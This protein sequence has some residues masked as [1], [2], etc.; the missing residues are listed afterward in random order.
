MNI[1][2]YKEL[3]RRLPY[4][5]QSFI[6]HKERWTKILNKSRLFSNTDRFDF[7]KGYSREDLL[8]M[9]ISKEKV[10]KILMWGYPIGGRGK[11]ISD[12]LYWIDTIV[13][14][15]S[16]V[17]GEDCSRNKLLQIIGDLDKIN[18][19]GRSTWSKFLYFSGTTFEQIPLLILDQKIERALNKQIVND[20][21]F[22]SL[23]K[24]GDIDTYIS[25]LRSSN[26][27]ARKLEVIPDSLELFFFMFTDVFRLRNV[28]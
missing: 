2:K 3:I 15:L 18:G 21:K 14:I 23:E 25:Y 13:E 12:L 9:P 11:N 10:I 28:G 17:H 20:I 5:D 1:E 22:P 27:L 4:L 24:A 7:E 8:N 6:P 26:A 16:S 19:M